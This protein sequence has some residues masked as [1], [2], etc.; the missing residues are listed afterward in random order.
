MSS[1]RHIYSIADNHAQTVQVCIDRLHE[2]GANA[3]LKL[4]TARLQKLA[5]RAT[6]GDGDTKAARRQR[7]LPQNLKRHKLIAPAASHGAH[8]R[9]D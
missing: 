3:Q 8:A 1:A 9:R 6:P 4:L 7:G 2:L 5:A